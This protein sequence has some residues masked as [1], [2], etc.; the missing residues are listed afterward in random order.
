MEGNRI[1]I[2]GTMIQMQEMG[3]S[4]LKGVFLDAT[5][6]FRF[7]SL[8]YAGME[9]CLLVPKSS[10]TTLTPARLARYAQTL[11]PLVDRPVVFLVKNPDFVTR[12]RY[13]D[14]GVYFVV[15]GKY[16]YL[17]NMLANHLLSK[18]PNKK[19]EILSPTSQSL[20]LL[21]LQD[22]TIGQEF[23]LSDIVAKTSYSYVSLTRAVNEL[24]RFG[25]CAVE[26]EETQRKRIVIA[27]DKATFWQKL[28]PYLK[29]PIK[30]VVYAD[31]PIGEDLP[32]CGINAL[33]HY[34]MLSPDR[35]PSRAIWE[36]DFRN[37][38]W[39]SLVNEIDG[40]YRIEVWSYPS[41]VLTDGYVD[42]LSLYLSLQDDPDARV[43]GELKRV[44]EEMKW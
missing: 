29:S 17:P 2:L 25:L 35:I 13:I 44:I 43:E 21:I 1:N 24:Q 32:V 8:A 22:P 7:Y 3:K 38:P 20:A 27:D 11:E 10:N 14:Q 23:F 12:T 36:R 42:R 28:R 19:S 9:C 15:E 37:V 31:E 26:V 16:A 39:K 33:A 30:K 4:Q 6:R 40:A 34:S 18:Q 41:P 5:L